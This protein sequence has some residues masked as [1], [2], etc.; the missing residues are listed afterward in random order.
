MR[1]AVF[2]GILRDLDLAS[3]ESRAR[4]ELRQPPRTV[5]EAQDL[6]AVMPLIT[7]AVSVTPAAA[8]RTSRRVD[9]APKTARTPGAHHDEQQQ[10]GHGVAEQQEPDQHARQAALEHGVDAAGEEHRHDTT[11]VR[12]AGHV[13]ASSDVAP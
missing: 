13:R 2:L 8:D 9:P 7:I 12:D 10:I 4:T 11:S 6:N 5:E 1:S 3:A